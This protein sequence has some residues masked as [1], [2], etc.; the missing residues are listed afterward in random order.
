MLNKTHGTGTVA[1]AAAGAVEP[2]MELDGDT[3]DNND[4]NDTTTTNPDTEATAMVEG[5]DQVEEEEEADVEIPLR[6]PLPPHT[7]K[8]A[9]CIRIIDPVTGITTDVLELENNEAAFSVCTCKFVEH[10]DE[11][12]VVVG[13]GQNVN[14]H[15]L[16][17][18]KACIHIYRI[19]ENKLTLVH[20]TDVESIPFALCAFNGRLLVGV[21]KCLRL[22]ELGKR[23][24]LR[25]CENK[26]FPQA[27]V[28]LVTHGERVYVGDMVESVHFVRYKKQES[29]LTI[30]ADDSTPK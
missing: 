28:K 11:T 22:Y 29:S 7:G 5:E 30:F 16:Q 21:G 19:V 24:L 2:K 27:I 3:T 14:L 26:N 10:S 20:S 8:W 4:T 23:K 13:I 12:F 17:F 15:P 9:S 1:G 25:K 6:G 18:S